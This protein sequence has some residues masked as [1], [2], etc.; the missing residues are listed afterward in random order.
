M[1]TA[2]LTHDDPVPLG[3]YR[4]I[5][6]L[7]SGGMGTVCVA[8]AADGRTVA[9]KTMHAAIATQLGARTRF[10]LEVDAAR[11]IG[12]RFGG[13]VVDAD[14]LGETP[15]LAT[16]FVLGPALDEAV[17][18]AGPLP[19]RSVR[20][21]GA[22][23]CSALHRSDVVHRDL[24]PSNILVTAYGPKVIDFGIARAIGDDPL[25]RHRR[26]RRHSGVHVPGAGYRAATRRGR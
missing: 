14:P 2:P 23:L 6:R 10:R 20:A 16:E 1:P 8:R 5:A 19:E 18:G 22:A 11:V 24:K 21:L 7:G 15:W 17:R 25:T 3:P 12:N 26:R 4:L 13:Q 9:L